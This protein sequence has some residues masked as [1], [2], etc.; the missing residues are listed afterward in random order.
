MNQIMKYAV[1]HNQILEPK[2]LVLH[3]K[4][5]GQDIILWSQCMVLKY[6][7]YKRNFEESSENEKGSYILYFIASGNLKRE[8]H[9]QWKQ[10]ID[11]HQSI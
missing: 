9:V 1:L 4:T 2:K 6:V 5:S 8:S 11:N 3:N 10:I 7:G